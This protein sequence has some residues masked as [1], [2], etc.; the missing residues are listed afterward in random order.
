MKTM[1]N[2]QGTRAESKL[3]GARGQKVKDW[4]T[5]ASRNKR[6]GAIALIAIGGIF[7]GW[8][9]NGLYNFAMTGS[10]F[11]V[12]PGI[13]VTPVAGDTFDRFGNISAPITLQVLG[14]DGSFDPK[15]FFGTLW[16][17]PNAAADTPGSYVSLF[18]GSLDSMRLADFD[19]DNYQ[20]WYI[21]YQGVVPSSELK[22]GQG[23]TFA[24]RMAAIDPTESSTW[25]LV[26][27]AQPAGLGYTAMITSNH[28][29]V[30]AGGAGA[31]KAPQ[32]MTM[33]VYTTNGSSL[34]ADQ[35]FVSYYDLFNQTYI[36]PAITITFAAAITLIE[37]PAPS[38]WIAQKS[39]TTAIVYSCDI[40]GA[41]P[42]L[43]RFEWGSGTSGMKIPA[44]TTSMV[45]SGITAV[46]N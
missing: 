15:Y 37:F 27:Y 19:V 46:P 25:E 10:F 44:G 45:A 11:I 32:N 29:V 4:W 9:V 35:A 24:Y 34:A 8:M 28:T 38:G 30:V 23:R 36:K 26:T 17:L 16:G 33:A 12:S 18:S 13:T 7:G 20:K 6:M 41:I 5:T 1:V 42:Q 2:P 21:G 40:I 3:T 31:V 14:Q 22:D 39:T 43:I